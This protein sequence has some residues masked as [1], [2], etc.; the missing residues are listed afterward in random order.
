MKHSV[1]ISKIK[2]REVPP[3]MRKIVVDDV[4]YF[5]DI[6]RGGC[7]INIINSSRKPFLY[8][9]FGSECT[10]RPKYIAEMIREELKSPSAA[11]GA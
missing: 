9:Y 8:K 11:L 7:S 4:V 6:G 10:W 5:Y 3:G 2:K 1:R